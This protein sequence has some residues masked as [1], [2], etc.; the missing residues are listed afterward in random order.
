MIAWPLQ[1]NI[2]EFPQPQKSNEL[3][4]AST[5]R[6]LMRK[7][8]TS[9]CVAYR[10]SQNDIPRVI[11][12]TFTGN[13]DDVI[14]MV[15][16]KHILAPITLT[17][18]SF[19]LSLDIFSSMCTRDGF[20]TC[21]A[22]MVNNPTPVRMRFII[23]SLIG[24]AFLFMFCIISLSPLVKLL[25]I[26]FTV[27]FGLFTSSSGICSLTCPVRFSIGF[28]HCLFLFKIAFLTL[29][30]QAVFIMIEEVSSG[31]EYA[32]TWAYA[33]LAGYIVLGYTSIHDK[34]DLLVITPLDG[35]RH[36]R[37][38]TICSKYTINPPLKQARAI[39]TPA[40]RPVPLSLWEAH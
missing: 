32:T 1:D 28:S 30:K 35:C 2:I 24:A 7:F 6:P 25:C 14:Y 31:R 26:S 5:F 12:T 38:T 40:P 11:R 8:V 33:L 13:R 34:A 3:E 4:E 27:L 16:R 15:L 29:S 23:G 22:V 20:L 10:A 9:F 21:L 18:L 37:G 17:F 39:D 19:E 36:R